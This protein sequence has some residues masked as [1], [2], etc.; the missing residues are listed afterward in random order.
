M[1]LIIAFVDAVSG[2]GIFLGI[3][4]F[5]TLAVVALVA[6]KMLK[7]TVKMAVRMTIVVAILLIA[8]IGSVALLWFSAGSGNADQPSRPR[9]QGARNAR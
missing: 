1:N 2:I 7:R 4:F 6:Y 9:P 5:I 3:T 8:L